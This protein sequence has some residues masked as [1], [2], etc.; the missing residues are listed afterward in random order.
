MA[1][2]LQFDPGREFMGDDIRIRRGIVNVHRDQGIVVWFN[3]TLHERLFTFQYGQDMNFEEGKR[4]NQGGEEASRS[5]IG[6]E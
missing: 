4:E 1:K 2:V 3:Q 6:F 5:C